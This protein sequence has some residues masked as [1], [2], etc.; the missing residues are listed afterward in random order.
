MFRFLGKC[1]RRFLKTKFA[2]NKKNKADICKTDIES[3]PQILEIFKAI[4]ETEER[5]IDIKFDAKKEIY[6]KLG[7]YYSNHEI[8][9]I[10]HGP[11][12]KI[13]WCM[14]HI[15]NIKECDS[16]KNA[17]Y[18]YE[19]KQQF[20][21]YVEELEMLFEQNNINIYAQPESVY[22]EGKGK[23]CCICQGEFKANEEVFCCELGK[24]NMLNMTIDCDFDHYYHKNCYINMFGS[25]LEKNPAHN[26]CCLLCPNKICDTQ[27]LKVITK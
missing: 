26:K 12:Q 22:F 2:F 16:L 15:K 3:D 17:N 14:A 11:K 21:L 1:R 25:N 8:E 24:K 7:R 4:Q 20:I 13:G 27:Q 9:F 18:T 5:K 19:E 6:I 10:S 23:Q